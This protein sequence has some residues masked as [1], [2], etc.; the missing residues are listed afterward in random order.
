METSK[1]SR[2]KVAMVK[3]LHMRHEKKQLLTRKLAD[4]GLNTKSEETRK[5]FLRAHYLAD[6]ASATGT[7]TGALMNVTSSSC[8]AKPISYVAI[9]DTRRKNARSGDSTRYEQPAARHVSMDTTVNFDDTV[10][11][12]PCSSGTN[13]KTHMNANGN[14]K[15]SPVACIDTSIHSQSKVSRRR[16]LGIFM[17]DL[18]ELTGDSI[19]ESI[20]NASTHKHSDK[21]IDPFVSVPKDIHTNKNSNSNTWTSSELAPQKYFQQ[22][23]KRTNYEY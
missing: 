15:K 9:K 23:L 1:K 20:G 19:F 13:M 7:G 4:T 11:S 10:L 2:S 17:H 6:K 22:Y 14:S 5:L 8:N 21:K 18:C 12:A 3:M 16:S